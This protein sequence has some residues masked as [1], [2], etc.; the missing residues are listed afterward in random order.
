MVYLSLILST[1]V[2]YTLHSFFADN[3][4]K[5]WLIEH[6]VSESHYRLYYNLFFGVLTMIPVYFYYKTPEK[7]LFE[8]SWATVILG[9]LFVLLGAYLFNAALNQYD[10]SDF[11]GS[12]QIKSGESYEIESFNTSGFNNIVRHPLYFTGLIAVFGAILISGTDKILIIS[13]LSF[14][15]LQIGIRL[16][17]KKLIELYGNA[18]IEY[19]KEVPMLFPKMKD[20][21]SVFNGGRY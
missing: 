16:E 11:S 19:K 17:E 20:L 2:F 1:V 9:V 12:K 21:M 4:V 18:Y 5:K 13:V 10:M 15:Y 7:I 6:L 3:A 14:L 8:G